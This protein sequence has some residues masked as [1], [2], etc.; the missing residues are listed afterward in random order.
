MWH[1]DHSFFTTPTGHD[2]IAVRSRGRL[3]HHVRTCTAT[4]A[5]AGARAARGLEA[6]HLEHSPPQTPIQRAR[7]PADRQ[8]AEHRRGRSRVRST[9]NGARHYERRRLA[10]VGMSEGKA[11][12]TTSLSNTR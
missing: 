12:A 6:V 8:E 9:G 2:V 3:H 5:L 10:F 1:S 11:R 7:P 4:T